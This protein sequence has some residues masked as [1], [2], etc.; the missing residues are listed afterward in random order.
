MKP[1]ATRVA[2]ALAILIVLAS[3]STLQRM[4]DEKGAAWVA[5]QLNEGKAAEL[6][7]ISSSPFLLDGEIIALPE[8]TTA[9]WN[10]LVKAGLKLDTELSRALPVGPDT[11]REFGSTRDV[12][13]FFGKYV[14][15]GA[16]LFE[17]ST[18]NG[19]RVLVLYRSSWGSRKLYGFKGPY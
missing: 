5:Q 12:Q 7:A 18:A 1:I 15:E 2:S 11:W 13:V 17:L 19:R 3:C 9:F 10:G 8:D 6:A 16:R 14:A 4:S